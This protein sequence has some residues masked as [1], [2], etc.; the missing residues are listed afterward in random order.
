MQPTSIERALRMKVKTRSEAVVQQLWPDAHVEVF[1]SYTTGLALPNSDIDLI[2]IG[3]SGQSPLQLLAA[4]ISASGIA[5]ANSLNV[6]ENFRIPLIEFID[7]E[8]QINVDMSFYDEAT[9][10]V[11]PLINGFQREYPML[12]K[13]LFVLKQYVKGCDL[14]D[15]FKGSIRTAVFFV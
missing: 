13:L 14:N 6:R 11:A 5:E 4:E 7:R 15:V 2:V 1:G 3:A 9:Q 10:K 12:L 8:S